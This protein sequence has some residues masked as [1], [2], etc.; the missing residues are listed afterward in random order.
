MK[1][2]FTSASLSALALCFTLDSAQAMNQPT[3]Q[4]LFNNINLY[5]INQLAMPHPNPYA[6]MHPLIGT[7]PH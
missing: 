3:Q 7:D 2:L 5:P 1:N 4:G 6:G